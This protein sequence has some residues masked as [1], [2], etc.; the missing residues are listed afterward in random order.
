MPLRNY[1]HSDLAGLE[2]RRWKEVRMWE[3]VRRWKEVRESGGG[4]QGGTGTLSGRGSNRLARHLI[5]ER[6]KRKFLSHII[7]KFE[8]FMLL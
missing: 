7:D 1:K 3:E 8:Y 6:Y 2:V 4:R 5:R